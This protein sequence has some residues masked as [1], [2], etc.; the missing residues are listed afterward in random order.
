MKSKISCINI[1]E[2]FFWHNQLFNLSRIDMS[3][4]IFKNI[5][6]ITSIW[7]KDIYLSTSTKEKHG[8]ILPWGS[9][10]HATPYPTGHVSTDGKGLQNVEPLSIKMPV[11]DRYI[12]LIGSTVKSRKCRPV[13]PLGLCTV[14]LWAYVAIT[15]YGM[16]ILRELR[17]EISCITD[18]AGNSM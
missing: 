7:I 16:V 8:E 4:L 6:S 9:S 10:P 1:S 3:L 5:G 18:T 14:R 13:S 12:K 11:A 2:L 17:T 15:I